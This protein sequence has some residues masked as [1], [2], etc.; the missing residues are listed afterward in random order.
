[1]AGLNLV[2]LDDLP[3]DTKKPSLRNHYFKSIN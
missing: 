3:A 2:L 1:M